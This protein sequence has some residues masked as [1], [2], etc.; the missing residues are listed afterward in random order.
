MEEE[1]VI[2]KSL[3][4]IFSGIDA[5]G[6]AF[7]DKKFTIDGRLVGDVG[8]IIA[9][10]HYDI[11]LDKVSR[12]HHDGKWGSRNVQIKATFKDSLTFTTIPEYYL[13]LKLCR[14]GQHEE[15]YNGPGI[16]I[17]ERYKNRKSI[18]KKQLSFPISELKE[19]T[20]LA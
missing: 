11:E 10:L 19:K 9:R 18:G 6:E 4:S 12:P 17:F 20:A 14:N 15:V 7:P 5:L 2:A 1:K 16:N 13:G 8:E 3:E